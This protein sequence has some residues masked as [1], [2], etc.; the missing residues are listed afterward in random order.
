V[1]KNAN[2]MKRKEEILTDDMKG[3][4]HTKWNLFT[5]ASVDSK[6]QGKV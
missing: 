1:E 2:E 4:K 6:S 5:N 3:T